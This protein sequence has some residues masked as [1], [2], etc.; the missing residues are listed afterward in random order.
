[1]KYV[2]IFLI[3]FLYSVVAVGQS[4]PKGMNYQAVARDEKGKIISNQKIELKIELNSLQSDK[5][6]I[7]YSEIHNLETNQVGLFSLIIGEG[8]SI[9]GNYADIPWS[10]EDIFIHISIKD[11]KTN[12]FI[13]VSNSKLQAV[14]YAYYSFTAGQ[15]SDSNQGLEERDQEESWRLDGNDLTGIRAVLGTRDCS[16]L[17]IISNDIERLKV[18]CNGDVEINNNL[19]VDKNVNVQKDLSVAGN[20]ELNTPS[21]KLG[22]QYT[23]VNGSLTVTNGQPTHLTGTL[24]VDQD[25]WLK[26]RLTVDKSADINGPFSVLNGSPTY[27]SGTLTVDGYTWLKDRLRVD[28]STN[29][30]DSLSVN[31]GAP[32]YLSGTLTVDRYTWLKDR[33]RVEKSTNLNDT[34][35]VNN[36]APTFLSGTLGVD[37]SAIF[38]DQVLMINPTYQS[39]S[40]S[41][42]TLVVS[43]GVG[44]AKNLYV[45]GEFHSL[46][47]LKVE[48]TLDVSG[49]S[50]F[51][52]FFTAH[53]YSIFKS[54]VK[55]EGALKLDSALV[56]DGAVTFNNTLKVNGFTNLKGMRA[57]GQVTIHASF[58]KDGDNYDYYPLRVEGSPQGIAIKLTEGTPNT[59]NNF[60]T[61]YN[62]SG[63]AVGAIEGQTS[64]EVASDPEFIFNEAMLVATEVTA[65]VNVGLAAIPVIVGGVGVSTGPCGACLAM[66][67]ADLALATANLVA[68]NVFAFENLGVTYSSGSADYAEWLERSNAAE[69]I[70]PGDIVGVYGGKVTK[71]TRDAH[72]L[73]VISTKPA[74]LG[75]V[76]DAGT[77]Y[78]YEKV[79][80]LGQIPVK[81]KGLVM[82]GDYILPSGL[83]DGVGIAVSANEIKPSQYKEIVGVAWSQSYNV[84]GYNVVN[85]AIGL[86]SNDLARLAEAQEKRITDLENKF[87]TIDDRIAALEKG[88]NIDN[89]NPGNNNPVV[90]DTLTEKTRE[91]LA[92]ANM[93]PEL[94]D[95]VM[96]EAFVY[97]K[98]QYDKLGMD[99]RKHPGL[100]R[101]FNDETFKQSV[102]KTTQEN[103]RITY[104]Q[105]MANHK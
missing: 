41:T 12:E 22:L 59:T 20:V 11:F 71:Y 99:V 90:T 49:A 67:A 25:T 91:Q 47:P 56:V 81:V 94:D 27:L 63:S 4:T 42:G 92:F 34:L 55:I 8:K 23:N 100:Y 36:G 5:E 85:M 70:T 75:N 88:K 102:I 104:Q 74:I 24:T 29:L 61:F 45:G 58:P 86:N 98:N 57:D 21:V 40:V 43:G 97:L 2:Y 19:R 14:P 52:G 54:G 38:K 77:E 105:V 78:L 35:L 82:T 89:P 46:G 76:P 53:K 65:G 13:T 9:T 62:S 15:L 101:L 1:M 18:F 79:A 73:M 93:P 87:K 80:F 72:Q 32:T 69:K 31:N 6:T 30:N 44:I 60:A 83:N 103:Y 26:A 33:L 64:S 50:N 39:N 48:S 84:N 28:K 3:S 66:A 95:T 17:V 16:D 37:K 7:Y 96:A 51:Y 10:K 68:F